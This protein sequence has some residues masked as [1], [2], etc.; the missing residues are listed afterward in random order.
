VTSYHGEIINGSKLTIKGVLD[1]GSNPD[2][3][4]KSIVQ[5]VSDG[6]EMASTGQ[7]INRRLPV[8]RLT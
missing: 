1:S 8:R 2:I 5:Y 3:S 7:V 4:T 6:D